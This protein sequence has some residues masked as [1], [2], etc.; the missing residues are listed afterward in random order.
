MG[1]NKMRKIFILV[2]YCVIISLITGEGVWAQNMKVNL[3][4]MDKETYTRGEYIGF[5]E[6][7]D[8]ELEIQVTDPEIKSFITQEAAKEFKTFRG[9]KKG[10]LFIE[11]EVVVKPGSVE[12]LRVLMEKC[13]EKFRIIA[14]EVPK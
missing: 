6:L 4:R 1:G 12:H 5:V 10:D 7:K 13:W 8:G 9:E 3:Y 11:K 14:E 2:I